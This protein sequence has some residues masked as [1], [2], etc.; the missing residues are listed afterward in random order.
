MKGEIHSPLSLRAHTSEGLWHRP[1]KRGQ[2]AKP[3]FGE[4]QVVNICRKGAQRQFGDQRGF[5][6]EMGSKTMGLEEMD[7]FDDQKIQ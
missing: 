2:D 5:K 7:V 6:D 1:L 4:L 3:A